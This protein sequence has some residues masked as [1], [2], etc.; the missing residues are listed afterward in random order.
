MNKKIIYPPPYNIFISRAEGVYV[1]DDIN[2]KKY[3]DLSGAAGMSIIGYGNDY[4][5]KKIKNQLDKLLVTPQ[6]YQTKE[7]D[8]LAKNLLSLFSDDCYDT[9]IPTVTGSESVEVALQL[10][11]NHTKSN[12]F[13]SFNQAYHGQTLAAGSLG[14][15]DYDYGFSDNK[16]EVVAVPRNNLD[17]EKIIKSIKEKFSKRKYAGFVLEGVVSNAGYVLPPSDF[18]VKLRN[19]CNKHKTLLI[20]DEVLTGFGRTGEIFSFYH[21]GVVPDIVC[22]AKG[23][24]SGY[25]AIGAVVTNRNLVCDYD[26]FATFAWSPLACSIASAN[27]DLINKNNLVKKSKTLGDF[28]LSVLKKKLINCPLV[29]DIRG[30]GL[31]IAI[32][33]YKKEDVFKI[34]K[35][36]LENG[37][38][39]FKNPYNKIIFIQPPLIIKKTELELATKKVINSIVSIY[40]KS[41]NV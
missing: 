26:Y 31:A 33:L 37:V 15:A 19:L 41:K 32:E 17:S 3:I 7:S 5:K 21:H 29:K 28:I 12:Y 38:F 36:C 11:I 2:N 10:S 18:Y 34:Y 25:S 40:N 13:L 35:E 20:F 9:V 27:I 6:K 4:I 39:V 14:E 16:F 24:S 23:L 8:K 22:L 30:L 1:Y